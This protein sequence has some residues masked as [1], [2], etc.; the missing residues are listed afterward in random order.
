VRGV[1]AYVYA[2]GMEMTASALRRDIYRVLDRVL[3]TGEP[4]IIERHGRRIRISAE[5]M[6]SRLDSLVRRP[7]VVVGDSEDFVHLDWSNEWTE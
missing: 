5:S 7:D 4:V 6:R 3:E 1:D 2:L